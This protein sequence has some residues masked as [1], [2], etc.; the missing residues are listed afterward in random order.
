MAIIK[1]LW[2]YSHEQF[3]KRPADKDIKTAIQAALDA[4]TD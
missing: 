1:P 4:T 3:D 2:I